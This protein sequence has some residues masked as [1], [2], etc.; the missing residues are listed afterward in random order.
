[1]YGTTSEGGKGGVGGGAG[2]IFKVTPS[3]VETVYS[4]CLADNCS[5]G[6]GPGAL[7]EATDGNLCGTAGGG[8]VY[9]Y[10]TVFRLSLSGKP[11]LNTLYS[12]CVQA[13]C[14][15]GA[16]PVDVIQATD[17]NFYGTTAYGGYGYGTVF[18]LTPSGKLT[19]LHSFSS[20]DGTDG[21]YPYGGVIQATDGSFYGTTHYGGSIPT[22]PSS[23]LH[24]MA[25]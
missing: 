25:Y 3:G 2:V 9:G 10:G 17:G 21:T 8:G 20:Y 22:A 5:D 7:I 14:T 24:P 16:N 6:A 13:G 23:E 19:T 18:R 4:F 15:D 11:T 1:M 12:F